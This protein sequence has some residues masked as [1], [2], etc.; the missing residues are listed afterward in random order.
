MTTP[1]DSIN[2]AYVDRLNHLGIPVLNC[3]ACRR[4]RRQ[5]LRAQA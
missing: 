3:V 1:H 4:R 2:L 5:S